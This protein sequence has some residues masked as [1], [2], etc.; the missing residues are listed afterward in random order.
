MLAFSRGDSSLVFANTISGSGAV[1]QLGSGMTTLT[2]TNSY[3]GGTTISGGTLSIA[4]DANLGAAAP[5]TFNGGALLITASTTLSTDRTISIGA[6]GG[7]IDIPFTATGSLDT[8]NTT[9]V[10][11]SG[12]I[13]GSGG[14]T[15]N[16]GSGGNL[17]ATA[18]YLLVLDGLN[19][20]YT[21]N[22]TINNATVTNDVNVNPAINI[23]PATTVL[24]LANSAV[25][26]FYSGNASQTLAGLNGDKTSAVGT[27]N[28]SSPTSLFIDP[29]A[30]ATYIFAG[31]IGDLDV[32][33][34]G[35]GGTTGIALT[36]TFSG[37][38]TQV[39]TGANYYTGA[40]TISSGTLQLGNNSAI[41]T[42]GLTAN[43]G[44]T[45]LHGFNP[46]VSS[47]SGSAGLITNNGA[48]DSLLTVNQA[49]L[50]TTF[51]GTIS[52][53]PTNKVGA[54]AD[55]IGHRRA[56]PGRQQYLLGG[57]DHQRQQH[58]ATRQQ[59]Q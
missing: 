27:E 58:A 25:F 22:T 45:D 13:T 10:K 6:S 54:D 32:L 53:G 7:T 28:N 37:Q 41:G 38:G 31:T 17:P 51:G 12:Q 9:G 50:A 34:R 26:A 59:R 47:L 1:V 2:G 21:G 48:S 43:G 33:G 19:N 4:G 39:L 49:T 55:Y 30:G 5:L 24:T 15:I 16:G 57:D 52:N 18:P 8:P 11:F 23:L 36:V 35:N 14:L 29:A 56:R 3:S 46:T 20:N 42:G 40:T 44:L